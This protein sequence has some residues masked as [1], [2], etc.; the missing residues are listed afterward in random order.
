MTFYKFGRFVVL[1]VCRIFFRVHVDGREQVP[2]EGAYIIAPT[3][4][5]IFDVPFTSLVTTRTVHFLAKE[6]LFSTRFGAWLFNALGAVP[7]DRGAAD[8]GAL[9]A[10]ESA[11]ERGDPVVV[12]PE[13]TRESGPRLGTLF[14]GAAY[15]SVKLGVPIVP[16][17]VGGSEHIL[18]KGK[19]LPRPHRVAVVVGE[20]IE[21]PVLDGRARR[22]AA[23]QLTESLGTE[24]QQCFD[25]A[26]KLAA[27]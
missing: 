4:R 5:S 10:L 13:G 14:N 3:H 19:L 24:L 17:G 12:F 18:P 21:P 22:G 8:R 16:V 7:V 26:N 15:L 27:G 23:V 25:R 9:R 6:E 2:P 1:G 20:P 11:L